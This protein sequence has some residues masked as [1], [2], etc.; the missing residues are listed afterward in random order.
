MPAIDLRVGATAKAP[1]SARHALDEL[2]GEVPDG[3]LE[4][5]RLLVSE[6]V[7]NSV[8]HAAGGEK[9][10]IRVR[11]T[12]SARRVRVEVTDPGPGFEAEVSVPSIY[13]E[14]GW[15]LFLVQQVAQ[16][17]GVDRGRETRVWFEIDVPR[18]S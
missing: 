14:S 5:V 16:R 7:T 9:S 13:Q 12:V 18:S 1:G 17:W 8:R 4:D 11:V 10:W 6:L 3:V 15:G 2:R